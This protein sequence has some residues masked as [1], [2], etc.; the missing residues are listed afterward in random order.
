MQ[1]PESGAAALWFA[2]PGLLVADELEILRGD[3]ESLLSRGHVPPFGLVEILFHGDAVVA[4]PSHL[5]LSAVV[6]GFGCHRVPLGGFALVLE[7]S[8]AAAHV[9][10][11][12]RVAGV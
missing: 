3:F 1:R 10:H 2:G 7:L 5:I 9:R 11:G 4:V 8:V 6:A 12:E